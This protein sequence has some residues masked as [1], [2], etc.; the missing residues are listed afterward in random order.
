MQH[1]L[2][3]ADPLEHLEATAVGERQVDHHAVEGTA[4]ER[5]DGLLG[6]AHDLDLDLVAGLEPLR[7]GRGR[8]AT[9]VGDHQQPPLGAARGTSPG[10]RARASTLARVNG[11]SITSSAPASRP[12]VRR[13]GRGGGVR[14]DHRDVPGL[15]PSRLS[16]WCRDGAVVRGHVHPDDQ[17]VRGAAARRSAARRSAYGVASTLNPWPRPT[18]TAA[19]HRSGSASATSRTR[20][21]G[22]MSPSSSSHLL[23]DPLRARRGS[24]GRDATAPAGREDGVAGPAPAA[25]EL[26]GQVERELAAAPG[27]ALDV[28]LAADQP[29]DLPADRQPEAGAAELA[30]D[31]AVRLLEGLEDRPQLLGRDADAG[32]GDLEGQHPVGDRQRPAS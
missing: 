21:P 2:A 27:L 25:Q 1:L 22:T 20:S 17:A 5:G 28:D 3:G 7:H 19:R 13:L 8:A 16:R 6:R 26:D 31:R 10:G 14:R 18:S 15:G 11:T 30:A 24:G 9:V 29:G 23:L 32:V 4:A 12:C